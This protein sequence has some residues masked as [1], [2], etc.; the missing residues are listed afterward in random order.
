MVQPGPSPTIPPSH[1]YGQPPPTPSQALPSQFPHAQLLMQ[2][3]TTLLQG[4]MLSQFHPASSVSQAQALTYL[5]SQQSNPPSGSQYEFAMSLLDSMKAHGISPGTWTWGSSNDQSTRAQSPSAS[6]H[7]MNSPA[8]HPQDLSSLNT[9]GAS[10]SRSSQASV[11]PHQGAPDSLPSPTLPP[12]L[13]RKP[14]VLSRSSSATQSSNSKKKPVSSTSFPESL[15]ASRSSVSASAYPSTQT[16]TLFT[17]ETGEELSFYVQIDLKNRTPV[18]NAIKVWF[19]LSS[20][21]I[22]P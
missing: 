3:S 19:S 18:C 1:Q 20:F 12:S 10:S 14:P 5:S 21:D 4:N 15:A 6:T 2:P 17:S 8:F 16:G 7:S 22:S 13:C 9:F 11:S